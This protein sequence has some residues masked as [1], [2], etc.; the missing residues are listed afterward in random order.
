MTVYI[1]A[2]AVFL[3]KLFG[4]AL[5]ALACAILLLALLPVK[6]RVSG[7]ASASGLLEAVLEDDANVLIRIGGKPP[8]D[9]ESDEPVVPLDLDFSLDASVMAGAAVISMAGGGGVEVAVLG[10]RFRP[11]RR[12]RKQDPKPAEGPRK[13]T[14]DGEREG[15]AQDKR[16]K[17]RP[18]GRTL[19]FGE[20]RKYFAPEVRE[21]TWDAVRSLVR[22]LH[23]SGELDIECGFPD[24]GV[25]GMVAASYWALGGGSAVKGISFRPNFQGEMLQIR[26]SGG[27]RLIPAQAGWVLCRYLLA[28]EIRPLWRKG[29]RGRTGEADTNRLER[30]HAAD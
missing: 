17:T 29:R 9:L 14:G 6:A 13:S 24:P 1:A 5:A 11:G 28:R 18:A 20:A 23:L 25:T 10:L 8:L 12:K 30:A 27:L 3:L 19:R 7:S 4:W 21:K 26:G 2:A 15:S 16:A 22:S